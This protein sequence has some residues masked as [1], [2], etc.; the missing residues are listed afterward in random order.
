MAKY[1]DKT[2]RE[3][4]AIPHQLLS[5]ALV[6]FTCTHNP[7]GALQILGMNRMARPGGF[8][9]FR[10]PC[11][12]SIHEAMLLK[13]FQMGADGV[14]VLGCPEGRCHFRNGNDIMRKN[15]NRARQILE[16]LGI[17][18]ERL[19]MSL[20]AP[21]DYEELHRL[22]VDFHREMQSLGPTPL[23]REKKGGLCEETA[24]NPA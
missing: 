7:H 1:E 18:K 23:R 14:M 4:T 9:P 15:V 20:V 16:G 8:I 21:E 10:V 5:P 19:R 24:G 6:L 13:A 22:L 11:A 2:G 3:G 17:A 12:G